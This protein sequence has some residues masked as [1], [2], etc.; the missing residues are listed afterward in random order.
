MVSDDACSS[1]APTVDA[2]SAIAYAPA[3]NNSDSKPSSRYLSPGLVTEPMVDDEYSVGGSNTDGGYIAI[4]G[5][6][7]V[8]KKELLTSAVSDRGIVG[9]SDDVIVVTASSS[10]SDVTQTS[11]AVQLRIV[12]THTGNGEEEAEAGG[13]ADV[14]SPPDSAVCDLLD[15]PY[16][17]L[18]LQ[19]L[20]AEAASSSVG[21]G[22]AVAA[23]GQLLATSTDDD[24]GYSSRSS[25]DSP[26]AP[27][28]WRPDESHEADSA[29]STITQSRLAD[30]SAYLGS[31]DTVEVMD[32]QHQR[33]PLERRLSGSSEVHRPVQ[34]VTPVISRRRATIDQ[35]GS[36]SLVNVHDAASIAKQ[37]GI[38]TLVRYVH[39]I[40]V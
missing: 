6:G 5:G 11:D 40:V 38:G 26:G 3:V 7:G 34:V 37:V 36:V 29:P 18:Q 22:A 35:A 4:E 23:A 15:H 19:Q 1:S 27:T 31:N 2:Y 14:I 21:A 25:I 28:P 32:V 39:L 20:A 17:G 13:E 33:R 10:D 12:T 8:A 9:S 16:A 30:T 24:D